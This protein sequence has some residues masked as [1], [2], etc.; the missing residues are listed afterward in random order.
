MASLVERPAFK[1][2]GMKMNVH[3]Y[4]VVPYNTT[5]YM[6]RA[7]MTC[8][9]PSRRPKCPAP[10]PYTV[11]SLE[12]FWDD[13]LLPIVRK[14]VAAGHFGSPPKRP[15]RQ[16]AIR[17]WVLMRR[18]YLMGQS[19]VTVMEILMLTVAGYLTIILVARRGRRR[20]RRDFNQMPRRIRRAVRLRTMEMDAVGQPNFY[21][22]M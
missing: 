2:R 15:V 9:A 22:R 8:P 5:L 7:T 14:M 16:S 20:A 4:S 13:H 3:G 1:A 10:N 18:P 17:Q 6:G 12:E 21:R 11:T 19:L